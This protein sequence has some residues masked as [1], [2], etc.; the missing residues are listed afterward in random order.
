M[1]KERFIP[2]LSR[3]TLGEARVEKNESEKQ[4]ESSSSGVFFFESIAM[5][6]ERFRYSRLFLAYGG[7]DVC[8]LDSPTVSYGVNYT[9][10]RR[11]SSAINTSNKIKK[12]YENDVLRAP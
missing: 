5:Y 8:A 12:I 10:R 11:V 7:G 2:D 3:Q 6:I 1:R 4:I 9:S